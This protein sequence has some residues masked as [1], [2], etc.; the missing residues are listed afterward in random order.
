M[1]KCRLA[2]LLNIAMPTD[3]TANS[4]DGYIELA[5][6]IKIWGRELGFQQVAITDIQLDQAA[7]RLNTWLDKG[8]QGE[9]NWMGEHG[10][11]RYRPEQLHPGTARVISVRMDYL[12]ADNNMIAVLKQQDT[13]YISRYALGRDYHKLI[14]KRLAALAQ[15]MADAVPDSV[16]QRPF[17]DSAPVLEK[18]LA[19]KA[20]L[21]W[22]G[23]NSLVINSTAGS[24]F[25]SRR[26]IHQ[27]ATACGSIQPKRPVRRMQSLPYSL[28]YRCISEALC[29][30]CQALYF[31]PDH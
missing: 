23:K 16:K 21:G 31:L 7:E 12:P 26:D 3:I 11:M 14:R 24:W 25:F 2:S 4:T 22:V 5:Q 20:G 15:K 1:I 30:G 9:M 29:T 27:P 6:Q 8:Y 28:P 13:A 17:V 18:A 10:E 19:E